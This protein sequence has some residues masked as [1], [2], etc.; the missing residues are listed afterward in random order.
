MSPTRLIRLGGR[1]SPQLADRRREFHTLFIDSYQGLPAAFVVDGASPN[2]GIYDLTDPMAPVRISGYSP[3][4]DEG[5]FHDLYVEDDLVYLNATIDGFLVVAP[6]NATPLLGQFDSQ[7]Y[8]H[9]NWVTTAGGRKV[10]V[11][12]GEG[13]NAAIQIVDVDPASGNFMRSIGEWQNRSEISVHNVMAFGE[14]AYMAHYED[15][16]RVLDL[17]NPSNP[18]QIAY[19]NTWNVEQSPGT[20]FEGAAGIDVD[21]ERSRIYVADST[22]GLMILRMAFA[23]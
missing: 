14:T 2:L 16:V 19:F 7:D 15:G 6:D 3:G 20:Y 10:S 1:S 5:A 8:S 17:S 18:T 22:R 4:P 9:S 13:W 11:H 12:G 21:L 23:Q